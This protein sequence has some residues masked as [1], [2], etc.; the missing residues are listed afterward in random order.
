MTKLTIRRREQIAHLLTQYTF[1]KLEADMQDQ[2]IELFYDVYHSLY[3]P[4]EFEIINS[5]PEGWLP[6]INSMKINAFGWNITLSTYGSQ[7]AGAE[8][9]TVR[10][11]LTYGPYDRINVTESDL[12]TCLQTFATASEKLSENRNNF[13]QKIRST[14]AAF[15]TE[16]QFVEAFPDYETFLGNKFFGSSVVPSKSLILTAQELMCA[17]AQIREEDRD[18]C[19]EGE[20]IS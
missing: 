10:L 17:V 20:V 11:P 7:C 9:P 16:K 6:N 13:R 18:G 3:T 19:C 1:K 14:L 12:V 5:L 15:S 4:A 8:W 2:E